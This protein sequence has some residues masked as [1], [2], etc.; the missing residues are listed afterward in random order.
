MNQ[1]NLFRYALMTVL[2]ALPVAAAADVSV[3]ITG[4][5]R[6]E[7]GNAF[8]DANPYNQGYGNVF[9]GNAVVNS[10]GNEIVRAQPTSEPN[11]SL[12]ATRGE[13]DFK[14]RFS[15]SWEGFAKIRGF[16]DWRLEG[17]F[18]D[19][20]HFDSGFDGGD[21]STL[22][23]NGE[24]YMVDLP[25]LYLDYNN[26]PLWLRIGNQQIAWGEAI[27]FRVF[28]VVNGLDLRRHS[29]LDVAAEEYSDKRV[30]SLGIRG[31]YR[32]Q[33]DWEI[34]GFVQRFRPSVLSPLDTPYN[35]VASQFVVRQK[36]GWDDNDD[37]FNFGARLSGRAGDFDLSFMAVSRTNPDGV[38]RW[39]ETKVNPCA[40]GVLPCGGI[41]ALEGL[42]ELLSQTAF[43]MNPD[44]V[45]AADEWFH[46]AGLSRLDGIGGLS[47]AVLEFPAA[48]ALG[49]FPITPDV[50]GL[51]G[52]AADLRSCAALELDLFFDPNNPISPGLG[53]LKGHIAREY[54]REEIF[55]AGMTYVFQGEPNSLFDQL[56]LRVEATLALDRK[57]TNLTLS[58]EYIEKDEFV[59]NVSFEKYHRFSRD[60]PATYFVL[61]WMHKSE[62]DML[63]RHVSG[64]D[65][66]GVPKGE[67]S[68]N[69]VAFALQQPFPGLIWRADL[70]V[71]YD[72]NG[73]FLVQP[74]A[75]WRPR[76]DVQLDIYANFIGSNGGNN[77]VMQTFEHMD[78]VFA[79]F[80]YYF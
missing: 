76:D 21:G 74:G 50:C 51:F 40:V 37:E 48:Q 18:D 31:S 26:G 17:E 70:A 36:Q 39:T 22:E 60:F 3:S 46:Y 10:F 23:I 34:E 29:F 7:T 45:W 32:F 5:V 55:G 12:F 4:F 61:Q 47:A 11:W 15:D 58:R 25:A 62:S 73:G 52:L 78:E 1:A 16:R 79:R 57:F 64:F 59:S 72:A 75:R 14:V 77:D 19:I 41:P 44:G 2:G 43:E 56:V 71:L 27:F 53:P 33:N 13:L 6:Q 30:P 42:G 49:A 28:D 54:F 35:F 38:F 66:D 67:S 63:G 65:S 69:A 68:F 80:T 20:D 9:S 24:D 8:S